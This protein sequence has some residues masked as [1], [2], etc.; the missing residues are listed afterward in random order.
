MLLELS[1]KAKPLGGLT[2]RTWFGGLP[3]PRHVLKWLAR[4]GACPL[5]RVP[6]STYTGCPA[7]HRPYSAMAP[8]GS[9]AE[10]SRLRRSR[11][12]QMRSGSR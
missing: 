7:A 5:V 6:S 8:N 9:I 3:G 11:Q 12:E 2:V 4:P 10:T 1:L